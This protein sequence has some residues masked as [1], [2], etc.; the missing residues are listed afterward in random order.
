MPYIMAIYMLASRR[1]CLK[2]NDESYRR[3]V[4]D[5]LELCL[6]KVSEARSKDSAI[7]MIREL[8]EQVKKDK[9]GRLEGSLWHVD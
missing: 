3:G 9:L 6:K 5:A 2:I 1:R 4:D 8:I 7:T